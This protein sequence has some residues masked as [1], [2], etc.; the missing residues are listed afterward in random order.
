[1]TRTAPQQTHSTNSGSQAELQ[2]CEY[3][4]ARGLKLVEKN[5]RCKRG[6]ID[7]IMRDGNSLVFVEVRYRKNFDY[8]GA[9][10]SITAKK[11]EKL[12]LTAL[13]YMQHR[14]GQCN[15]RFDVIAIT[16]TGRQQ[17]LEWISNAF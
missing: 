2:A 4:L 6:E 15:V 17:Q 10:A 7:L 3:L 14:S 9:A 8:G 11:Q 13:H 5:Y 1:M 12:Q 16:G